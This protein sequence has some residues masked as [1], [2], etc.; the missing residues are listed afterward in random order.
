MTSAYLRQPSRLR[1]W[2]RRVLYTGGFVVSSCGIAD[3]L[4]DQSLTRSCRA[5]HTCGKIIGMYKFT[6]PETP[7]EYYALHRRAAEELLHVC[8]VNEGLYVKMGQGINAM[9]HVLPKEYMETLKVLLDNAKPVDFADVQRTIREETGRDIHDLFDEID[10]RPVASAS[11]AQV[12]RAWLKPPVEGGIRKEVAVK[13]RKPCIEKQSKWD[14]YTFQIISVLIGTLFGLPTA[15]SRQTIVDGLRREMDFTIEADNAER[16]RSDL[17]R[18][19]ASSRV[20]VPHI[21]G[22]YTSPRLLVLEWVEATKL[23]DVEEVRARYDE[24]AVLKTLFDAFGDMVFKYGFVHCDP[25]P[26]N[27]MVRPMP[28]LDSKEHAS[29]PAM[30]ARDYQVVLIDFGLC[31]PETEEFRMHYALLFK[32]LATRDMKTLR[33]VVMGWGISDPEVFASIQMQKPLDAMRGGSY[34]EVTKEEVRQM[35]QMAHSRAKDLL[36]DED[37]IPR[38]LAMVSRSID[39]LRSVNRLY[40]SPINRV[41]M[42]VQ[43]A[44]DALGPL[45]DF[46]GVQRYLE[47]VQVLSSQSTG[48]QRASAACRPFRSVYD[49]SANDLRQVQAAV[50]REMEN[51][52]SRFERGVCGITALYRAFVFRAVM[53]YLSLTHHFVYWHNAILQSLLPD[54]MSRPLRAETLDDSME[55]IQLQ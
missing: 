45:H 43:S 16:I 34:G 14:I 39:I 8:L 15:W 13:V 12:H 35:Q 42:F 10:P 23:L 1:R 5:L 18:S 26:A 4:T 52:K 36:L 11:I 20:Y 54:A 3:F 53:F 48:G 51:E 22:E 32:S 40:D 19:G 50:V 24:K 9:S 30:K 37:R 49:E 25:H 41:Q 7:E 55:R 38:E 31:V 28:R 44:V 46:D 27:L 6:T 21:Y 29:T 33:N 2:G 17:Q 47:R